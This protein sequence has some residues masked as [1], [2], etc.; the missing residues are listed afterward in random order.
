MPIKV[1]N[2]GNGFGGGGSDEFIKKDGTTTTTAEIPFAEG[3]RAEATNNKAI[4]LRLNQKLIFD[5]SFS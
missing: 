5:G 4:R 3:I 1:D 2:T